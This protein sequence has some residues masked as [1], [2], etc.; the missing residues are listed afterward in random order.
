M[1]GLIILWHLFSVQHSTEQLWDDLYPPWV[2]T[3]GS[4]SQGNYWD[5]KQKHRGT[6][7]KHCSV[8]FHPNSSCSQL[9]LFLTFL[10][11]TFVWLK[12]RRLAYS[13][14]PRPSANL[15][16]MVFQ[17]LFSWQCKAGLF[18][19]TD[20]TIW[21]YFLSQLMVGEWGSLTNQQ[22]DSIHNKELDEREKWKK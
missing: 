18:N 3:A 16:Q 12:I 22:G 15:L 8:P 4:L 13:A 19:E 5:T 17:I 6:V 10:C 14:F 20:R 1:A 21:A 11:Q 7:P 9:F 2:C